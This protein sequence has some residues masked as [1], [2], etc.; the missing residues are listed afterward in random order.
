MSAR[1][2]GKWTIKGF[3]NGWVTRVTKQ[4]VA[5]VLDQIDPLARRAMKNGK[6]LVSLCLEASFED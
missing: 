3:Q 1:Q 4:R 6:I 2:T 5:L